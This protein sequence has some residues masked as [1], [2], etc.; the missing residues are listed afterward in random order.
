[1][2]R[3]WYVRLKG[4]NWVLNLVDFKAYSGSRVRYKVYI[5]IGY[6]N[7]KLLKFQGHNYLRTSLKYLGIS[8]VTYL[9]GTSLKYLR[10]WFVM[11][12]SNY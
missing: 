6:L 10:I 7:Q 2:L 4:F 8:L 5:V 9:L 3:S 11:A 1:M 12:L